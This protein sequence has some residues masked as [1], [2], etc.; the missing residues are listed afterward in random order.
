MARIIPAMEFVPQW[1]LGVAVIIIAASVGR[2]FAKM[3]RGA[4]GDAPRA[5]PSEEAAELRQAMDAMQ[6][7]L[8]EVEERL[9]FAERLLAN[10]RDAGRLGKPLA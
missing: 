10:Q 8:A 7:R 4:G 6:N 5:L 2:A 3:L 1:A 9:D